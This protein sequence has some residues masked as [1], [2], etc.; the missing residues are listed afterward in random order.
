MHAACLMVPTGR[1]FTTNLAAQHNFA[2]A[3]LKRVCFGAG[4]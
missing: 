3:E 2:R 4:T 1:K